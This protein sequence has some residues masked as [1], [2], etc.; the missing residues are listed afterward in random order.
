MIEDIIHL[1]KELWDTK[2]I[3][4]LLI[5]VILLIIRH[6]FLK[7]VWL[8]TDHPK[9][10]YR[11]RKITANFVALVSLIIIS[12]FLY[13][14]FENLATF[15]GL[16]SAGLA[17][18]LKDFITNFAAWLYIVSK[19]PFEVGDRIQVG[20]HSGDVIDIRTFHFTLMEIGNWV[21]AEQSTGRVL[22]IPNINVILR[23][24]ANYSKGFAYI[25]N[26]T[27]VLIS[28]ESN[29]EKAKTIL[30]EIINKHTRHLSH[31]AEIQV[32]E[33]SK[34]YL[35]FYKTLTP[36]VYTSVQPTGILLTL[37]YLCEPRK[38]RMLEE[39]IWE[40]ILRRFK[41]E[42]DIHITYETRR[43]VSVLEKDLKQQ[44]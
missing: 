16:L 29:W 20:E 31:E 14:Y 2:E 35:L 1:I 11:Y 24:S 4:W 34:K 18:A 36:I 37:R 27:K 9:L 21:E 25:W 32:K 17:T 7:I 23:G 28:F 3:F 44:Q 5:V 12:V 40:D 19:R 39:K 26:E 41:E 22:Q 33:A 30:T 13:N 43:V 10:R 6:L 42:A 8:K 15:L 38:R